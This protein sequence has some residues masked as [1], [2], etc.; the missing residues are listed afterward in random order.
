MYGKRCY[1]PRGRSRMCSQ[2]EI[3][4]DDDNNNNNRTEK[5]TRLCIFFFPSLS[6]L[7]VIVGRKRS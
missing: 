1:K 2:R 7:I 3:N 6:A 5:F 4:N